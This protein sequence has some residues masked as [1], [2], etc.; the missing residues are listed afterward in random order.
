MKKIVKCYLV[1]LSAAFPWEKK[2]VMLNIDTEEFQLRN[3]L[4]YWFVKRN[5]NICLETILIPRG[6]SSP[7]KWSAVVFFFFLSTTFTDIIILNILLSFDH[8]FNAYQYR[9]HDVAWFIDIIEL[10]SWSGAAWALASTLVTQPPRDIQQSRSGRRSVDRRGPLSLCMQMVW[11]KTS[12]DWFSRL[13]A[14]NNTDI[15]ERPKIVPL[16][17]I[18]IVS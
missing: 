2:A 18:F 9:G 5:G 10:C 6:I 12:S 1:L 4:L 11:L 16:T 8:L 13:R 3:E 15:T 7:Q 14:T 17:R